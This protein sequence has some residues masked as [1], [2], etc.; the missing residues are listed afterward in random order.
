MDKIEFAVGS[1]KKFFDFISGLN[2][3]DKIALISHNDLDGIASAKVANKVIEADVLKFVAYKEIN[4]DFVA[5]LKKKKIKKIIFTDINM[6]SEEVLKDLEKF[7]EILIVD[8]HFIPKDWNSERTSYL[9]AQLKGC[10]AYL[11]YYLFSKLQ[12][13]S[14]F[15]WLVALAS[16]SDI[17]YGQNQSWMREVYDKYGE[18]F[19]SSEEGI[20]K[21]KFWDV[22]LL[23]SFALIHFDKDIEKVY[24]EV[25]NKPF[26]IGK[27]GKYG[28]DIKNE[29]ER[30]KDKFAKEKKLI[31]GRYF[32]EIKY[33]HNLTSFLSTE[34]S[35]KEPDRTFIFMQKEKGIVKISARRQDRREN[36]VDLVRKLTEGFENSDAGGHIPAAAAFFPEKYLEEFKK[37]LEKM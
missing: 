35:F 11:C 37:R 17:T 19:E 36:M 28:A 5:E 26:D 25:G 29:I 1:E 22:Q 16:V 9:N 13:V 27:L 30:Q 34:L 31:S 6:T 24:D 3:K 15:D 12:D 18:K 21:S 4:S 14:E 20:K 33:S 10:A 2:D 8:H 23:I 7:A 32:F